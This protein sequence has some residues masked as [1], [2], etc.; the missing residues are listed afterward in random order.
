MLTKK[1]MHDGGKN[2]RVFLNDKEVCSSNAE[3]GGNGGHLIVDGKEWQT[4]TKM[5]ECA[6]PVTV[7]K[8]D[9]ITVKA[10]YD[11]VAHPP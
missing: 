6:G 10:A 4:I 7:K 1:D 2:I 5:T 11:T 8:G 9:Y 3:Y